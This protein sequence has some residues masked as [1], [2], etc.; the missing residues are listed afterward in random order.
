MDGYSLDRIYQAYFKDVY[1]YLFSLCLHHHT[2]PLTIS[3]SSWIENSI[4]GVFT[5]PVRE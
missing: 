5:Y 2:I 3:V 1:R 4:S